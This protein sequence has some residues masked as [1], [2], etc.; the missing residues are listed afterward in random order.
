MAWLRSVTVWGLGGPFAFSNT[1]TVNVYCMK[2][3][4][5]CEEDSRIKPPILNF[6]K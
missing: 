3:V 1:Y 5:S 2:T 4:S 6:E